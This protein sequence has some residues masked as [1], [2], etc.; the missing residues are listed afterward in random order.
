M[1][2]AL[3]WGANAL[4]RR[5]GDDAMVVAGERAE[6]IAATTGA[7]IEAAYDR[8]DSA[9][10][11]AARWVAA[12]LHGPGAAIRA[13]VSLVLARLLDRAGQPLAYLTIYD[14]NG[15]FV[16][17][18]FGLVPG[19]N[20]ADRPYF[21]AHRDSGVAKL[22]NPPIIGRASGQQIVPV[23]ARLEVDGRFAGVA[24]VGLPIETIASSLRVL[25]SPPGSSSAIMTTEGEALTSYGHLQGAMS[26][27][28]IARVRSAIAAADD[29]QTVRG[30][31]VVDGEE[32]IFALRRIA[33]SGLVAFGAVDVS[34]DVAATAHL[35]I[36]VYSATVFG[37]L[38]I[39]LLALWARS[40]LLRRA[41][42]REASAA[43]AGRS[44]INR[45]L[46]SL[47]AIVFLRR[48]NPDGSA[49]HLYRAGDSAA[50]SGWPTDDLAPGSQW[51]HLADEDTDFETFYQEVLSEGHGTLD[52]RMRQPD[53]GLAWMR[54]MA[55]LLER[56]P[57]GTGLVVG[58]IVNITAQRTAEARAI[59]A[60][61]LAS[62][63]EMATS[64]AHEFNQPM[65]VISLAAT[66][67]KR[68][69]AKN[70]AEGIPEAVQR[71]DRIIAN[72]TR[73]RDLIDHLRLFGR[74]DG[75]AQ[76]LVKVSLREIAEGAL[77]LTGGAL[78]QAGIAVETAFQDDLP[79]VLGRVVPLEQA[80]LN[81][82]L[83]ARDAIV[84]RE[85]QDGA[86]RI[87]TEVVG[88]KVVLTIADNGGGIP[89]SALGRLFEPFFT[90]KPPGKG[91]G[92][93]LS[94]SR[95]SVMAVGGTMTA[96]N[97]DVGAVFTLSFPRVAS[98]THATAPEVPA[99]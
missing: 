76:P 41:E 98:A 39:V 88:D 37:W 29:G 74:T 24:V 87:A 23:T 25:R 45:L 90:T 17:A 82:I 10:L 9:N 59:E 11:L 77:A 15:D 66:N 38:A 55:R 84:E 19:V 34:E 50:V 18:T 51:A 26:G 86:I 83:N 79:E 54:S 75:E 13:E 16:W 97:S 42:M 65:A 27:D 57:D 5:V 72:T 94:V 64:L 3:L 80:C 33:G 78:K 60:A 20:V 22:I 46:T 92:L 52:W 35:R 99:T 93:G 28:M 44:E 43:E 36:A 71:L 89:P 47:P 12:P 53:G 85:R 61:R 1:L 14:A 40:S 91:T 49:V 70:G 32:H 30:T 48:V 58:Y 8:A 63:G 73:A 95:S 68:T 2:A 81:L 7:F 31:G 56:A 21:I 4:T 96:A 6:A 62:L 69:L 67:A